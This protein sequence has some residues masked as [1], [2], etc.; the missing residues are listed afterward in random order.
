MTACRAVRNSRGQAVLE[1]AITFP[2]VILTLAAVTAAL[3]TEWNRFRCAHEVFEA[4]RARLENPRAWAP[5]GIHLMDE[6]GAVRGTGRC[7][8]G[9]E[10]VS[11]KRIEV[12]PG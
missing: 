9:R 6:A 12:T 7:G 4:T 10:S 11:L 5:L 1:L 3:R 2:L 8:Q